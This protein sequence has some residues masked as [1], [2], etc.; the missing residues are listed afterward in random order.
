MKKLMILITISGFI[1]AQGFDYVGTKKCGMCH[2][3]AKKGAQLKVWEASA[4]ASAFETLKSEESAKIAEKM[5]LKVPAYE[6]A[7]CL[8]CHTTGYD[9]GG[10]EVKD[11]TF[12]EQVTDK[13]K[14]TKEV[15]LMTGLQ[16]VSCEACHGAGSKYKSIKVMKEIYAGTLDGKTVGLV[17]P[18]E[19]TC[20]TCHNEK[21]PTFKSFVF[22]EK[23]KEI[24]HPFLPEMTE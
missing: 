4:H 17:K 11:T 16:S 20:K 5:G 10:Y 6:A 1:F 23:V 7:E 12:W 14:P 8:G 2:K 15:K 24:A 22:A 9:N 21:S 19:A 18:T 13:G 3:S